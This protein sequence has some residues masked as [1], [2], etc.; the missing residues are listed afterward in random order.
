MDR[1]SEA[2]L[3]INLWTIQDAKSCYA[4]NG[5]ERRPLTRDGRSK[6][7]PEILRQWQEPGPSWL[8]ET[9]RRISLLENN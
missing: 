7:I 1:L 8:G 3:D 4:T 9:T 5:G 2:L 6:T